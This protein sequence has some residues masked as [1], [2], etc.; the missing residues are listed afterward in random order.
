MENPLPE[1]SHLS[2]NLLEESSEP[3]IYDESEICLEKIRCLHGTKTPHGKCVVWY[4]HDEAPPGTVKVKTTYQDGA[5]NGKHKEYYPNGQL[6][7]QVEFKGG[8]Q[9]GPAQQWNERG[10]KIS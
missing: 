5:P 8:R 1:I 9:A 4:P 10:Q 7:V 2:V 3:K 6:K